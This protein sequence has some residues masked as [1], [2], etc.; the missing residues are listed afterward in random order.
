LALL[1]L[2][3][4]AAEGMRNQQVL[5]PV[6]QVFHDL[7]FREAGVRRAPEHVALVVIDEDTLLQFRD[8]PIAFWTPWL[9]QATQV[10]H[11]A[12][13]RVVGLDLLFSVS[14]EAWL[15]KHG[16]DAPGERSYDHAFR[17]VIGEG[18][19]VQVA[20]ITPTAE[21]DSA[22]LL[23]HVDYLLSIPSLDLAKY[24]GLSDLQA[25]ADNTVRAYVTAPATQLPAGT[26]PTSVPRLSLAALLAVRAVGA[27]PQAARWALGGV[28][29][30]A[31][32]SPRPIAFS[33]PPGTVPRI[34]MAS[35]LAPDAL[36]QPAVQALK[37]KVVIIGGGYVGMDDVHATPYTSRLLGGVGE[38]MTGAE[39]QANIVEALLAGDQLRHPSDATLWL[40][41][42]LTGAM[43]LA[44][45]V[46]APL[47]SGA[48]ILGA[49]LALTL[50]ASYAAF[51]QHWLLPP[52]ALPVTLALC[53]LSAL[54]LKINTESRERQRVTA[55]FGRYV[56][57]NVVDL[58]VASGQEPD[59]G[60]D[61]VEITVLFTD[62][63]NFTTL[64]EQ[65]SAKEV[66]SLLNAYLERICQ[67]VLAHGGTIDKI[68]GDAVMVVFG[69]PLLQA[70]HALRAC[71]VALAVQAESQAF[72]AWVAQ[73][74]AHH[75]LPAFAV[76]VGIH[77]GPAVVGSIGSRQR[78]D[79]TAIG[80]A[81][82]LASRIEGATKALA[83]D[84]LISEATARAAG[85]QVVLGRS[86]SIHVKGRR[87]AV[88]V[89]ALIATRPAP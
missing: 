61:D 78:S 27:D 64:S 44:L 15:S 26:D 42:A 39:L 81:V 71:R 49:L 52:T 79:Y 12:G 47:L 10:A 67:V 16:V 29:I 56:A 19:L 48:L 40:A 62:I 24:L 41:Q 72:S 3:A 32:S 18:Q 20:S 36:Q 37:D 50:A 54:M 60:G 38:F 74:F 65:L 46:Q 66:V 70:D 34:P 75:D 30:P 1:L 6:D 80:D 45:F 5:A 28:D 57:D 82:N 25:D 77:T 43:A 88:T 58:L 73:R 8:D 83:C 86:D 76:G 7:W 85:P 9:A 21:G 51:L 68:I 17:Q 35:L 23:P 53:Y 11:A 89:H 2:S 84:I 63:R 87:Q 4:L 59:L 31:S 14:P 33:G 55:L 69:A 13:A 22:F